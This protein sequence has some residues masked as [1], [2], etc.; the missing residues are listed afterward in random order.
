MR[1]QLS[2][3]QVL[4]AQG[5]IGKE[6][7]AH[8]YKKSKPIPI[9]IVEALPNLPNGETSFEEE[10]EERKNAMLIGGKA[11][12]A[13]DSLGDEF[14]IGK[15]SNPQSREDKIDEQV[16]KSNEGEGYYETFERREDIIWRTE[17]DDAQQRELI[18]QFERLGSSNGD[19]KS[20]NVDEYD[21]HGQLIGGSAQHIDDDLSE[22]AGKD[23]TIRRIW[24]IGRERLFKINYVL[25]Y[26]RACPR[27]LYH[28][29][30]L[31]EFFQMVFLT[32]Y[33]YYIYNGFAT[34]VVQTINVDKYLPKLIQQRAAEIQ[35]V[36]QETLLLQQF[37]QRAQPV[38][39]DDTSWRMDDQFKFA[40]PF[41]YLFSTGQL[42]QY[43][44][45]YWAL[46]CLFYSIVFSLILF[47]PSLH[48]QLTT[49]TVASQ[50]KIYI[51][52]LSLSVIL[53][54]TIL[55]IPLLTVLLQVF[56]CDEKLITPYSIPELVCSGSERQLILP[57]SVVTMFIYLTVFIT[58]NLLL[59]RIQ[60]GSEQPWAANDRHTQLIRLAAK[61]T[62]ICGFVFDKT[63]KYK[64][65]F[66]FI[67]LTF[68]L[69][70]LYRRFQFCNFYDKWVQIM[71]TFYDMVIAVHLLF[72]GMHVVSATRY[73]I[74]ITCLF[75]CISVFFH[76][77]Y[78]QWFTSR[79]ERAANKIIFLSN[80][81]IES[82]QMYMQT[83]F[84]RL[85]N[86]KAMDQL[87]FF[88][89]LMSHMQSCNQGSC[90]CLD[91]SEKLE[92]M[93]KFE[94]FQKQI[95]KYTA[96]EA[97]SNSSRWKSRLPND[98]DKTN[99]QIINREQF[100]GLIYQNGAEPDISQDPPMRSANEIEQEGSMG[101]NLDVSDNINM[102][103]NGSARGRDEDA[104]QLFD[105]VFG[106]P[107][108]HEYDSNSPLFSIEM[109]GIEKQRLK[110]LS[111]KYFALLLELLIQRF[112][113][114]ADHRLHL[115]NLYK[116]QLG[117][118]FKAIYELMSCQNL[119]NNSLS[120]RFLIFE[121]MGQIEQEL[122]LTHTKYVE[123]SNQID[124]VKVHDYNRQ[125]HIHYKSIFIVPSLNF[126]KTNSSLRC[127]PLNSGKSFNKKN[128][129]QTTFK[130]LVTKSADVLGE[131][132]MQRR[133]L[134]G[135]T[136]Q[137]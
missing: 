136:Q 100:S 27:P 90:K 73:Q 94:Q 12:L 88:G 80:S 51:K 45:S 56:N 114:K 4:Q 128:L 102:G 9:D 46:T 123:R 99:S 132:K 66:L 92:K 95:Q 126:R 69:I 16:S 61:F 87:Y 53:F 113:N 98:F 42:T 22:E 112:P 41:V 10:K 130:I 93:S 75:V 31:F 50:T 14:E 29:L 34:L 57:F 115:A 120:Q 15:Q 124:I 121:L 39:E 38:A 104:L 35:N 122:Q 116:F 28:I 8:P 54:L 117:K 109:A 23:L 25:L 65:E 21:L 11:K 135:Y 32:F 60:Y 5:A 82:S 76:Q 67:A 77:L 108:E 118:Q 74:P 72:I 101:D 40:N 83:I 37:L 86:A 55:Q 43:L 70:S 137:T 103:K 96:Q 36:T 2:E 133:K 13:S 17:L 26:S 30:M 62:L 3:N 85:N 47:G 110:R 20:R 59:E 6:I 107:I 1:T 71:H 91:I 48:Q 129:M 111:F 106:H 105:E 24:R 127:K 52:I 119:Y 131:F 78:Y 49:S 89:H 63:A 18:Q 64:A 81:S 68:L 134:K 125:D 58:E 97:L 84:D 44:A 33:G 79:N 19:Q 7:N